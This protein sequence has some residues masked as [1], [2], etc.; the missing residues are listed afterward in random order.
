MI[1]QKI[2]CL[3][4]HQGKVLSVQTAK[5]KILY[6]GGHILKRS[7]HSFIILLAL[8]LKLPDSPELKA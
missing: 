1:A 6:F 7:F 3:H 5:K 4:Q 8:I 2:M